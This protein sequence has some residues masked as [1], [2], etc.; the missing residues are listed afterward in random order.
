MRIFC[1]LGLRKTR[2]HLP[3]S[4]FDKV[5]SSFKLIFL[6]GT[7]VNQIV[8]NYSLERTSRCVLNKLLIK[9]SLR[10]DLEDNFKESI[11]PV[12]SYHSH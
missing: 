9:S 1:Q 11:N 12:E 3:A 2:Y 10:F 5:S 6:K 8:L 4:Y 7:I